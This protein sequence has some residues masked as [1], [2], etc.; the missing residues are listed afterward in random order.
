MMQAL[1]VMRY[2]RERLEAVY[3][4]ADIESVHNEVR[5]MIVKYKT[6]ERICEKLP[7]F[8]QTDVLDAFFG[9]KEEKNEP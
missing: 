9:R 6:V 2:V 1:D 5:A 7:E 8:E 4:T 3:N